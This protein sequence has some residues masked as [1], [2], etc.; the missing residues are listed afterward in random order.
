MK[1]LEGTTPPAAARSMPM[2]GAANVTGLA[3]AEGSARASAPAAAPTASSTPVAGEFL[4]DDRRATGAT[5]D[6]ATLGSAFTMLRR[7]IPPALLQSCHEPFDAQAVLLL[8][9]WSDDAA[10]QATQ[11]EAVR[12]GQIGRAH[13]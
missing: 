12:Q 13:F 11:R 3:G 6:A 5:P 1:A 2:G 7:R 9:T 10:V 8:T 4:L